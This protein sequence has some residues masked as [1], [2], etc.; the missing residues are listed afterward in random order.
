M[1]YTGKSKV[2]RARYFVKA[3]QKTSGLGR[4]RTGEL[5]RVKTDALGFI[6]E[7]LAVFPEWFAASAQPGETTTRKASAPSCTV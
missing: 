4:I 7:V 5:R 2:T 6:Q 1:R 3:P